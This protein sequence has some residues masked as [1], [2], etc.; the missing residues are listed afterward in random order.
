[1]F[2]IKRANSL[3]AATIVHVCIFLVAAVDHVDI[4]VRVYVSLRQNC[5]FSLWAKS[6]RLFRLKFTSQ[7]TR[8]I[9]VEAVLK[10]LHIRKK[11]QPGG[12]LRNHGDRLVVICSRTCDLMLCHRDRLSLLFEGDKD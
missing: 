8:C 9:F 3:R 1:M 12:D 5:M 4:S 6:E 7:E 10:W 2:K 11:Q